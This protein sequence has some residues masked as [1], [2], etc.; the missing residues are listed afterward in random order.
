MSNVLSDPHDKEL[1]ALVQKR[2][3]QVPAIPM[4]QIA[5]E[6]GVDVDDLCAWIMRYR[7][8]RNQ[9]FMANKGAKAQGDGWSVTAQDQRYQNW[10]R[11]RD[12]AAATLRRELA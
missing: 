9:A 7:S 8:P 5:R 3:N 12:G 10:K 2:V 4:T 6:I 11:A 1:W